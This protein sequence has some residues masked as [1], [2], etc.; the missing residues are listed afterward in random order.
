MRRALTLFLLAAATAHAQPAPTALQTALRLAAAGSDSAVAALEGVVAQRLPGAPRALQE[1]IVVYTR[2]D[3]RDD[4]LRALD[5]AR[6]AG[7]DFSGIAA[8]PELAPLR[9]DPRFAILFP[10]PATFDRP[11]VEQTRIIHE[12]RGEQAGDEFGWIARGIGDV[13]R[14]GVTDVVV[15]ATTNA[16]Y[17][18]TRGKL[19]VY[20]G[21]SGRLLWRREGEAGWLLG[22]SVEAAGDVDRDGVPDVVAGAPGARLVLVLSGLD[23]REIR[24]LQGDSAEAYFGAAVSGVGDVDGDGAADLL[25]GAPYASARAAASGR[26]IV[27][28]GRTGARLRTLDGERPNDG[29]G[30]AVAGTVTGSGGRRLVIG[31]SGGGPDHRGRVYVFDAS[32]SLGTTP[33]FVED[34]D[35][36]GAAL[37]AMFLADAGDVDGDGVPDVYASDFSNA[38]KGPATGRVYVYSGASGRTV[39]ALTGDAGETLGTSASRAGDVDGDG[40]ADLAV[41]A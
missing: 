40:R 37:G 25:V 20:S 1:L 32:D 29:F 3:R 26:A 7:A 2:A 9:G 17:G 38:A 18:S 22:T 36:T 15:S 8:R 35:S 19:Y 30:S 14:D 28:S 23:G 21:K 39:L 24:R 34:A 27:F 13:D 11:F 31:A 41:G 16:P 33:R 12:W 10:A 5:Q 4:A 6:H